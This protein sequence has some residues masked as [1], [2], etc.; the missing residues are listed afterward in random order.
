MAMR[1]SERWWTGVAAFGLLVL[2]TMWAGP[3]LGQ[4]GGDI[5]V[6]VETLSQTPE[7]GAGVIGFTQ[8]A[9]SSQTWR[10][11]GFAQIGDVMYVA[12]SFLQVRESPNGG[13]VHDQ[14]YLA[15]FDVD[16]GAWISSFRP[17]LDD[18]VWD[19]AAT[20]DGRL[21]VGGEFDTVNGESRTGVVLLNTD[22]EIDASF[23]TSVTNVGSTYEP[24][25]R[26]IEVAGSTVYLAG[27]FNRIVDDR[28]AHGTYRIGRVNLSNG[29]LQQEWRPR[30]SGG[31]VYDLAVDPANDAV[32]IVGTFTSV[33]A[34]T[35]TTAAAVVSSQ[36]GA[37]L[38][39]SQ[40][41]FNQVG[42]N[43]QFGVAVLGDDVWVGGTQHF[44]QRLDASTYERQSFYVTSGMPGTINPTIGNY[45]STGTGGDYQFVV[46]VDG[47]IVA[48]CHCHAGHHS[49]AIN[50]DINVGNRPVH[51]YTGAGERVDWFPSL[52][53]WNEGPYGAAG[54]TNGCLWVGGDFTGNVDGFARFCPFGET[55]S[56]INRPFSTVVGDDQAVEFR[57]RVS[58]PSAANVIELSVTNDAG[59]YLGADGT[60]GPAPVTL[61]ATTTGA[62]SRAVQ[63]RY[64]LPVL[65]KGDYQLHATGV[66]ANGTDS[67]SAPLRVAALPSLTVG[68]GAPAQDGW[69]VFDTPRGTRVRG[70]LGDSAMFGPQGFVPVSSATLLDHETDL[71]AADLLGVDVMW[72]PPSTSS[73]YDAGE[74]DTL[75]SW[76]N[77][78]GVMVAYSNTADMDV[79]LERFGLSV[80]GA[81]V[82]D[83][84]FA[85][86][87]NRT[88]PILD[89]VYGPVS[90]TGFS[91]RRF[92]PAAVP[93]DWL[94]FFVNGAGE[95]VVVGGPVGD[96]YLVAMA[97]RSPFETQTG[98]QFLGNLMAHVT[99][100]AL[101]LDDVTSIPPTV[102]P[103]DPQ[104]SA[105]F[106]SASLQIIASDPDGGSVGFSATGLPAG[107]SINA[108]TGLISGTPTT[109]VVD[110]PVVVTVQDDEGDTA[111]AAFTWTV[112]EA[113][114]VPPA[115]VELT[116]NGVDNVTIEWDA[117]GVASGYLI[118][119]DFVFA[120]WVVA[121]TTSWTD[122]SVIEG[123]TYRY[124]VR[125]QIRNG[126][127]SDPSPIE[128]ITVGDEGPELP[129]FGTPPN[130]TIETNGVDTVTLGWDQVADATGYLVHR[131]YQFLKWVPFSESSWVDTSVV[132]GES[133]RYQ[134][135]A[136]R[137]GGEYSAPTDELRITVGNDGGPDTTPPQTPPNPAA[138]LDGDQVVVTWDPATDDRGVTG[139]LIHRNWQYYGFVTGD[140]TTF[141][142]DDLEPGSRYRYQIRAQDA[143]GN[144]S[145]PTTRV[146]VDVP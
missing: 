69:S 62:G 131:D 15:A 33:D 50:E 129:P 83:S 113:A 146:V 92:D 134:I 29:R 61:P 68:T 32:H 141:I 73:Q 118:H 54:D 106:V 104:T 119:R 18:V 46:E 105:A 110:A 115:N 39:W 34:Q 136:Q 94:T 81:N 7:D 43:Q 3:A 101:E 64:Q 30:V 47:Y 142:D 111:Q 96:G 107:L 57:A 114:L 125:S 59:D 22:G 60:F 90:L 127:Y 37:A 21:V 58:D 11:R 124:Q 91:G 10:A 19:I 28:Y 67:T 75:A 122:T 4:D 1:R 108:S 42:G 14:A 103:V 130:P 145:A 132:A 144:N 35:D 143:A 89:G 49:S 121:G 99:D 52:F 65:P 133:Y 126:D 41:A 88:H 138:V 140:I 23:T 17:V 82:N 128:M 120:K 139:Y 24:S 71:E 87:E 78:G 38:P 51:V 77:N 25:V 109:L 95:P 80:I 16:T 48:G 55:T 26:T 27:D 12:G 85:V 53:T 74:L 79:V 66:G 5:P 31:G 63:A 44:L 97:S 112:E 40:F 137:A 93:A 45:E 6:V 117:V 8:S 13:A 84:M 86:A 116:T 123:G 20:D 72:M 100:V 102:Q 2:A 56:V 98:I 76:V 36:T 135:R 9:V 70:Q